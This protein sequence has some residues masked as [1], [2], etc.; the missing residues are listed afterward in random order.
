MVDPDTPLFIAVE[1]A[2]LPDKN[3]F[4]VVHGELVEKHSGAESGVVSANLAFLVGLFLKS[5]RLGWIFDSEAPYQCFPRLPRHVRK[6][7]FS[8]IRHGRL[9]GERL[10]KGNLHIPPDLAVE[11]VSNDLHTEIDGKVG[12]YLEV[13]VPL[14]WVINPETRSAT[15]YH[16]DGSA[17]RLREDQELDGEGVLPGFRCVIRD[18]FPA[19]PPAAVAAHRGPDVAPPA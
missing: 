13:G 2:D 12:E 7:D 3:G 10:P 14:V 11:V 5:S 19:P 15:V 6:P 16:P 8:F 1:A 17:R 4:E 9:R 18:L